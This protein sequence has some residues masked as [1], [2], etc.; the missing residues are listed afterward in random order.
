LLTMMRRAGFPEPSV[1]HR[2]DLPPPLG[3]TEPDFHYAL[4]EGAYDGIAIYLDGMS[5]RLHGNPDTAARDRQIRAMLQERM[6]YLVV[7]I[8]F[9]HL[10][11]PTAMA[12]HM[13]KIARALMGKEHAMRVAEEHITWFRPDTD[14]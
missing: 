9:G 1:H 14:S 3:W 2:V 11:D 4:N 5:G 12:D 7:T 6:D 10:S 13:R 8:P